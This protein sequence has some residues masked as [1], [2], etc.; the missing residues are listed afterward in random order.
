METDFNFDQY[1][2]YVYDVEA[3]RTDA[4]HGNFSPDQ[5]EDYVVTKIVRASLV[6]GQF[7][8]ARQQCGAYGLNYDV[9]LV[10]FKYRQ[11]ALPR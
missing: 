3:M 2:P 5:S 7:D 11:E 4:R 6:N 8:Q 1:D 10:H 9:E